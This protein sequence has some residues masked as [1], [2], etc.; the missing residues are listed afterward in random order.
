VVETRQITY[1]GGGPF[2]R[3]LVQALEDEGVTVAVRRNR[4]Y[5]GQHRAPHGMGDAVTAAFVATGTIEAINAGVLTF[6]QRFPDRAVVAIDEADRAVVAIDEGKR[7]P[8][9]GRHR[10]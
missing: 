9:Q 3:T 5:V 1:Q 8:A 2:L 7:P 6:R 10:A 4:T